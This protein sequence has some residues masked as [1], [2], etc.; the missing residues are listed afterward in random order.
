V[1]RRLPRCLSASVYT[2]TVDQVQRLVDGLDT[3]TTLTWAHEIAPDDVPSFETWA[4]PEP[5]E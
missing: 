1:S 4:H 3:E 2:A 5:P